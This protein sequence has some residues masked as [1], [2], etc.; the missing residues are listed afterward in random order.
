VILYAEGRQDGT[1][2]AIDVTSAGLGGIGN[3]A[4]AGANTAKVLSLRANA[5]AV[6]RKVDM[7]GAPWYGK[8]KP[9]LASM[10]WAAKAGFWGTANKELAALAKLLSAMGFGLGAY[11]NVKG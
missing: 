5:M 11:S 8:A 7:M 10:W 4:D 3:L 6:L 2:A 1:A 9:G